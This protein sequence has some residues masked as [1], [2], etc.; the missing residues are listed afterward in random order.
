L[1]FGIELWAIANVLH[2][3]LKHPVAIL[4]GDVFNLAFDKSIEVTVGT[5][6]CA[7]F[8]LLSPGNLSVVDF[9]VHLGIERVLRIF[10]LIFLVFLPFCPFRIGL[11]AL[12]ISKYIFKIIIMTNTPEVTSL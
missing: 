9:I 6:D 10:I 5:T 4:V 3:V 2:L 11:I 12:K 1:A 7:S 8:T